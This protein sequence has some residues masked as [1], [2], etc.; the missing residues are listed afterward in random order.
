M[1]YSGDEIRAIVNEIRTLQIPD[2]ENVLKTKHKVFFETYPRL[3][4]AA[5]D[6]KFPLAFLDMMLVQRDKLSNGDQTVEETD[7][8]VYDI[9]RETYVKLPP[10]TAN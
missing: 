4:M 10:A 3:F 1:E 8:T 6:P 9:L 7:K 2:K 5:L